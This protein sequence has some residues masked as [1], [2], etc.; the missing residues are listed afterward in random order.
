MIQGWR[1]EQTTANAEAG[2]TAKAKADPCGM[3]TKDRQR[4]MRE[5]SPIS[6]GVFSLMAR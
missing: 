6:Q 3:T 2:A 4:K 1:R 5:A